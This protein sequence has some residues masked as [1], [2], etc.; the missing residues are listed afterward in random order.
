MMYLQGYQ[1]YY[2]AA[3]YLQE[4]K[5]CAQDLPYSHEIRVEV[6]QGKPSLIT[7]VE[8]HWR[9]AP[10]IF[11]VATL[12][13]LYNLLSKIALVVCCTQTLV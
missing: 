5:H 8:Y 4:I 7:S 2:I 12:P 10:T 3:I 1:W 11:M 13:V 6:A 9:S